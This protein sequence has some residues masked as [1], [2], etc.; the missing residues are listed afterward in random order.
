MNIAYKQENGFV[1]FYKSLTGKIVSVIYD[2]NTKPYAE[3]I[4]KELLDYAK[5]VV[6]LEFPDLELVPSEDKCEQAYLTAKGTEYLLAVGS[7]TL[8]DMAKSVSTRLDI[9]CGVLATAASM[10]GYCSKG[11]ALMWGGVKVT[12]EVH[13]PKT[14]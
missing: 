1:P 13:T 4:K 10:D 14:F 8:N 11:A 12:D 2:V 6:C 7:G 3:A 5:E 9:P